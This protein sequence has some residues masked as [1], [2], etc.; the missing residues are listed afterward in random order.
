MTEMVLFLTESQMQAL[1]IHVSKS[2]IVTVEGVSRPMI[3][4]DILPGG[5]TTKVVL[6]EPVPLA[7]KDDIMFGRAGHEIIKFVKET[8]GADK[9]SPRDFYQ[10]KNADWNKRRRR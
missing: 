6:R 9:P 7:K 1:H 5:P 4:G 8:D 3:V 10:R 2:I